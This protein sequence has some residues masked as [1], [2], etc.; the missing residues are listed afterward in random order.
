MNYVYVAIKFLVELVFNHLIYIFKMERGYGNRGVY[1]N[2]G[3]YNNTR[4]GYGNTR[5]GHNK[6]ANNK[7]HFIN[8]PIEDSGFIESYSKLCSE[9]KEAGLNNFYP[10]LL[11]KPGKIHMTLCVLDLGEDEEK[12]KRVHNALENITPKIKEIANQKVLFNFDKF[13]SMG[14]QESSRVIYAKMAEDENFAKLE[15]IIHIIID[16]LVKEKILM[17]HKLGDSHVN[18]ENGKYKIKLHMTLFNVLFLN[19][20][21]KKRGEKEVKSID[22]KDILTYLADKPLPASSIEQINFSKMRENP[23]TQQYELLYSYKF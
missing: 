15:E 23:E 22:A 12:I 9:I 8:I 6:W 7:S 4:G 17:K 3:G 10:E 11:Q 20:V 5:G 19:K 14:A 1:N 2:R 13:E 18:I 16:A 21:L